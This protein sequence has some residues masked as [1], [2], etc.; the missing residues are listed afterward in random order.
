MV[1][2]SGT[3]IQITYSAKKSWERIWGAGTLLGEVIHN[4]SDG[5]AGTVWKKCGK[6]VSAVKTC[7]YSK[8][9]RP[10]TSF[11]HCRHYLWSLNDFYAWEGVN[12]PLSK[13]CTRPKLCSVLNSPSLENAQKAHKRA[14]AIEG[15]RNVCM[16]C[17][18]GHFYP[19]HVIAIGE[20]NQ[21]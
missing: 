4:W 8:C 9:S 2:D 20:S 3:Y 7:W 11:E 14:P 18:R 13:T 16:T 15:I 1:G 10:W 6:A 5:C 21:D 17:L 12:F 19:V